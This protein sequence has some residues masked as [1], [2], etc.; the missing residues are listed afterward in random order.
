METMDSI[1]QQK[2]DTLLKKFED[3]GY[4]LE[5]QLSQEEILSFLN[6]NSK[7]GFD[8]KFSSKLFQVLGLEESQTITVE[9]FISYYIQFE[10]DLEQNS[11]ELKNKITNEQNNLSIYQEE[12]HKYKDEKNN[13]EGFCENAKLYK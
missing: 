1:A 7:S 8:Q 3:L 11:I 10:D 6:K 5:H 13:E 9:D 2:G 4:D 12:A